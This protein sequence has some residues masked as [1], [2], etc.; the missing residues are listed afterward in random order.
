MVF[1]VWA[2][3]GPSRSAHH[4]LVVLLSV[5]RSSC[6]LSGAPRT[7]P[8]S[9]SSPASLA[10]LQMC[11]HTRSKLSL[12]T[13]GWIQVERGKGANA[14][15]NHLGVLCVPGSSWLIIFSRLFSRTGSSAS[16]CLFGTILWSICIY[17]YYLKENS[18]LWS[19]QAVIATGWSWR[20]MIQGGLD[21]FTVSF[22]TLLIRLYLSKYSLIRWFISGNSWWEEVHNDSNPIYLWY[23]N[24][25]D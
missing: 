25:R 22:P 14:P 7:G 2:V 5:W 6:C 19:H 10:L 3:C 13:W 23:S 16:D 18:L 12:G 17:L 1:A 15:G 11:P 21:H 4:Y 8:G 20:M 9:G 24:M